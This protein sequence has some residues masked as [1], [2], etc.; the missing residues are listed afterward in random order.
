MAVRS[1]SPPTTNYKDWFHPP[2]HPIG[3]VRDL[4]RQRYG[5]DPDLTPLSGERD[6][7]FLLRSNGKIHA[8]LKI[9]NPDETESYTA[10]QT[11]LLEHLADSALGLPVPRATP[12]R[13][14]AP[15]MVW[16]FN[17]GQTSTARLVSYLEGTPASGSAAKWAR[18]TGILQGR[19]CRAMTGFEHPGASEFMP[20]NASATPLFEP[21]FLEGL[22]PDLN[23]E[24]APHVERLQHSA[25]QLRSQR[26]QVIHNDMHP[27][28]ILLNENGDV[29]GIID[30]GDAVKGPLVQDLAVSATSLVEAVPGSATG[31]LQDLVDGFCEEF[32]LTEVELN[33]LHD[34]M[35]MR[36]IMSVVLGRIK[37]HTVPPED[38]P[39]AATTASEAGLRA[40]LA[41]PPHITQS[42]HSGGA[43]HE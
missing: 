37:D 28:N 19:L 39:R 4:V 5:I 22:G 16:T 11:A 35:I 31:P 14:G 3:E 17:N 29:S 9:S 24:L 33:L 41:M 1:C 21:S 10:F 23:R 20:W 27:G 30:F 42:A 38:R 6:Q 7:N 36:S 15:Y 25:Q 12:T 40:I 18:Q 43:I 2:D 26:H 32:P 13:D 34:A 8:I